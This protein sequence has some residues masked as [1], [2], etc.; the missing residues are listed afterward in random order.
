MTKVNFKTINCIQNNY[1]NKFSLQKTNKNY[2]KLEKEIFSN[3]NNSDQTVN[4]LSKKY[5]L[6]FRIKD[7]KK[8]KKFKNIAVIGMGGSI[9]GAEAIYGFLEKKNKKKFLFL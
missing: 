2:A 7:I 8:Y 1:L 3:I 5:K 4:I 6:S 9:L